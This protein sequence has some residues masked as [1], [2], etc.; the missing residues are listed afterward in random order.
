MAVTTDNGKLAAMTAGRRNFRVHMPIA[1]GSL[2]VADR[3]QLLWGFPEIV[4]QAVTVIEIGVEL[5][6][7]IV[8]ALGLDAGLATQLNLDAGL[9]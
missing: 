9:E 7:G 4:W 8:T 5:D 2:T 1:G 6:A 3:Q